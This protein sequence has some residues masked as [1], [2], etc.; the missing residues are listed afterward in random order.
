MSHGRYSKLLL[1]PKRINIKIY[2][3]KACAAVRYAIQALYRTAAFLRQLCF[4]DRL[5][6]PHFSTMCF[7]IEHKKE[8][9]KLRKLP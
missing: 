6:I 1:E 5:R 3:Y 8:I 7:T 2:L 4:L 9:V